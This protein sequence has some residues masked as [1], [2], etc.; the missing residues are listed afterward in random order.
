VSDLHASVGAL[1]TNLRLDKDADHNATRELERLLARSRITDPITQIVPRELSID[2]ATVSELPATLRQRVDR[3]A[4]ELVPQEQAQYRVFRREVPVAAP[5]L[6]L[7]TPTWGRGAAVAQTVGPF[8]GVDGRQFWFD[9]YRLVRLVPVYFAGDPLPA[10]LVQVSRLRREAG[11]PLPIEKI[12][13]LF[14]RRKVT[15]AAGSVWLRADL[16]TAGA[17]SGGYVGFRIDG[18][19]LVFTPPP[20]DANG[21]LTITAGGHCTLA[22]NLARASAPPA[23]PGPAGSD[24]AAAKLALPDRVAFRLEAG[25][26]QVTSLG[27]AHFT[28][29]GD[30]LDFTWDKAAAPGWQPLL[31]SVTVPLKPSS[32]ILKVTKSASLFARLTAR[33]KIAKAGWALPVAFIDTANPTEAAGNGGLAVLGTDGLT[34]DWRG[35]RDG[36][37]ALRAPLIS[38]WPGLIYIVD[39]QASNRYAR[40]RFRLWK[41]ASSTFRS[42]IDLAYSDSFL[43]AYAAAAAGAEL[44]LAV[45]DA[46]ARLD[47]P[48][49]VSSAPFP[50]RT[51]NSLLVLTYTNAAQWAFLYDDNILVDSLDPN[52]VWPVKPGEAVSLAIRNAL[53]TISPVNSLLFFAELRD[54]EMAKAAVVFVSMGLFGILP[55]LPDPY[56]ANVGWLRRFGRRGVDSRQ[57]ELLLVASVG[58][59]KAAN[60][61]DPDGVVTSFAFA[62]LGQQQQ[63]IAAWSQAAEDAAAQA[64]AQAP[65]KAPVLAAL[66]AAPA[67]QSDEEIWNGIFGIFEREQFSLLDVSSNADQMGVSFAWI[68]ERTADDRFTFYRLFAP[69]QSQVATPILPFAVR[70]LDLSA[71]SRYVRAFTVPQISWEPLFNLSPPG[72]PAPPIEPDPPVG[73]NLYPNDGGPTRLFNDSVELVPIAPIPVT[74]FLVTDFKDRK[75]GFTGALFTLPFG[76]KAFAEFSRDNPFQANLGPAKVAYNRPAFA[77]SD[78]EGGLQIRVDAPAAPNFSPTFRGAA[79]QLNNVVLLNGTGTGAGTLGGDVAFIFNHNFLLAP[80]TDFKGPSVP[81]SRIDFCGYGASVFSHWQYPPAAIAETSQAFFDIFVGRTAHEVVQVRSLIYPWAIHV[82]R[83]ITIFRASSGYVYR[84]D[85]GWQAESDGVYNFRTK[86]DTSDPYEF[87]PGIVDGVYSVRNIR[88]DTGLPAFSGTDANG[89]YLLRPVYFDADVGIKGVVSG[90]VN[91]RVPSKGV[92]GYV[93][94]APSGKVLLPATFVALLDSQFG[95]IGGPVDCVI[96][97]GASGQLMRLSRVDVNHAATAT[98]VFVSAARGA[99]VLPK[100]GSWSVIEHD[101]DS[102]EV[103]PVEAGVAVPLIRRGKLDAAKQTTDTKSTDLLR[104]ANPADILAQPRPGIRNYGLLQS[105]GTQKALFRLPS[106]Q[107]GLA[108]LVSADPDFA[109]AYRMVNSSGIFPNVKD[110]QSLALGSFQTNIISEGYRLIDPTDPGKPFERAIGGPLYLINEKFLKI[111]V[112]YPGQLHFGLDSGA[113]ALQD[114]WL[115]K[116]QSVAMVVDLGPLPR[117]V[118]ITGAFNAQKGSDPNLAQPKMTFSKDLQPIIDILE[119]LAELQ[120]PGYADALSKGLEIAMS[121]S[122]ASW[123]YAFHARKEFPLLKFPPGEAYNQPEVPLKLECHMAVGVYFNEV[124]QITTDPKQLIPSAG[125]FLEFGATLSV[126]CVSLELATVYAVGTVDLRIGADIKTGPSLHMTFGFGAEVVVGLPVV[127]NV[128]LLYMVGVEINLETAEVSVAAF[129]LFRGRAELLGGIVTVTI[130]IEAKGTYDRKQLP[131]PHT[132]MIAQVTFGIDVSVFLVINIHFSQSWQESR[133]IA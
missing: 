126:M 99:I 98:A 74:E 7:A 121:N 72:T 63:A 109:D 6:D 40:Q 58:W 120:G 83:T 43:L 101:Q 80:L 38:L 51:K 25:K 4:A 41:D 71:E 108:Q 116:L 33:T 11:A 84:F 102:G 26:V 81:L 132:D 31:Q 64:V 110:T 14:R 77:S 45:A 107:L 17:P 103:A 12:L 96:N 79:M 1:L 129:L 47:R 49:D 124:L 20:I 113:A 5:T 37:I 91:G 9:F 23:G 19:D 8:T 128:S 87:H 104:L 50:V 76:M 66:V 118:T 85:S 90:A 123:V 28:L 88:E 27:D 70:D 106:F 57:A 105:T 65:A 39:A 18:G 36:P 125:A 55:T 59:T 24:A 117:L 82:V 68:N 75:N 78:V 93:Q 2:R 48:V 131:S 97:I 44:L 73:W 53:F 69:K 114:R 130:M 92:L 16:L 67:E 22:L 29:Y 56:A 30:A 127:G 133:Q 34:L 15:L 42:E 111:Y 61:D 122:A 21:Q 62:P 94:L 35:L 119:I 32:S 60:D 52:A 95:A 3:L 100:D 115:S 46:E 89:D 54:E 112:E 10:F 86:K 13:E